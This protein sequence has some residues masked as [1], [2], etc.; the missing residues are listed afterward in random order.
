M[1]PSMSLQ[2]ERV[3]V[4]QACRRVPWAKRRDR[5]RLVKPHE[6]IKLTRQRRVGVVAHELGLGPVDHADEPLQ[7]WLPQPSAKRFIPGE[8]EQKARYTS[9][10]AEPLVTVAV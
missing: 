4:R 5:R 6:G 3:R 2:A 7:A 8:V 9:L 10:M 1:S